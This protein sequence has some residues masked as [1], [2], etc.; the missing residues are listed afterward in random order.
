MSLEFIQYKDYVKELNIGKKLPNAVYIHETALDS[1]PISLAKHLAQNILDLKLEN[2]NWNIIKFFKRDHKVALLYYPGFDT[3]AYPS[4]NHSYIIDLDTRKYRKSDYSKSD[5]PPILH[6]KETFVQDSYPLIETFKEITSEGESIDLYVNTKRIGFKNNWEKLIK[7]KGY[8]LDDKGRLHALDSKPIIHSNTSFDGTVKRHKT[9][10][11]R[12]HLSQPMQALARHHYLNGDFN[13]LDYGCGKGDDV[14]ELEAHGVNVIG[15]D[16]V[17]RPET[18]RTNQDIVNIGFVI[19]VIEDKQERTDTLKKAWSYAD[20]LLV[21]AVMIAGESKINEFTPYKDGVITS[22]HTF[23]KYYSQGEIRYYIE[24]ALDDN[25][26]PIGQG[27]FFIFKDKINEQL[28]LSDRQRIKRDWNQITQRLI[29]I[30]PKVIHKT[31]IERNI[32]LFTDYWNTTLELGRIPANDEFEFSD[33]IRRITGSHKKTHLSLIKYFGD[34]IFFDA[35]QK[36]KEDLLVYFALGLFEK[37][38]PQTKMPE[39][40]KRDIKVFFNSITSA[41]DLA[42]TMLFSVG[43][44]Q[45]INDACVDAFKLINCG[46]LEESHSYTFHKKYLSDIPAILRIYVGCAI[47]IYGDIDDMHLIKT[48]IRSSKVSLMRYDDWE[49]NEPLLLERIKIKLRDLDIEFY[50]YGEKYNPTPLINKNNFLNKVQ[51]FK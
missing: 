28:F 42:K 22:I 38:R 1:I 44:P 32:E 9:A 21:V 6:R 46:L 43:N 49:K 39:S 41:H 23:Q 37:R 3:Y 8:Y 26:I 51:S 20:K 13:V 48:H 5:N 47:Q 50:D 19:N 16:P 40:L 35:Q 10:I 31:I 34:N 24:S 30:K 36:R 33:Q 15:W 29:S 12:N 17:H 25:A 45:T 2:D 18:N 7:S 4:L 27:I 14:R 11:D